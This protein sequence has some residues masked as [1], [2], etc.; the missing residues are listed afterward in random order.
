VYSYFVSKNFTFL[1]EY[2]TFYFQDPFGASSK[3]NFFS[4]NWWTRRLEAFL[5]L[6]YILKKN[7]LSII[8]NFDYFITL[9]IVRLLSFY[10]NRKIIL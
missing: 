9:N 6:N 3:Y 1:K 5:F 8:K 7:K 2:L 4:K 10:G